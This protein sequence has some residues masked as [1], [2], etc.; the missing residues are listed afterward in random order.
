MSFSSGVFSP[1]F[2]II[3][4][5]TA[6]GKTALAL[7]Q[8]QIKNANI[9]SFDSRQL[10]T[11][12]DIG[13]G[14]DLP[15]GA[16]QERWS[17]NPEITVYRWE[18]HLLFGFDIVSPDK[19]FSQYDFYRYAENIIRWHRDHQKSLILVG[20]TWPYA[21]V[22]LNPPLSL[23]VPP[24]PHFRKELQHASVVELQSRL[25]ELD[26]DKL[27]SFNQSDRA[28]PRRLV[29]ALEVARWEAKGLSFEKVAPVIFPSEA[30]LWLLDT[31]LDVL[32]KKLQQRI[33]QR[34]ETGML[35]EVNRLIEQ[36]PDWSTPAFTA[37]GYTLCRE[38]S[39]QKITLDDLR[40]K[41]L[42][43]ER[44]YAVR[45]KTWLKQITHN[46]ASWLK[47]IPKK[48]LSKQ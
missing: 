11:G 48:I 5:P 47:P 28:N 38:Y 46:S 42:T 33:Q 17:E 41:W 31:P 19:E 44:Q 36:Y 40:Q 4:G 14:K 2:T 16:V 25:Q 3:Y 37:T 30:E 34:L 8:A 9:L 12:M 23:T 21:E 13:T 24:D 6:S 10:Y 15:L 43:V 7:E 22:L 35:E 45:Q 1:I 39:E 26:P 27:S 32:E 29:R 18:R 20:G